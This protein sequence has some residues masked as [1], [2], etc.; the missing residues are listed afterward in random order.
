MLSQALLSFALLACGALA[1]PT[2]SIT[3][4]LEKRLAPHKDNKCEAEINVNSTS[5]LP[6]P[7]TLN[8]EKKPN[9]KPQPTVPKV[10]GLGG[11]DYNWSVA[12]RDNSNNHIGS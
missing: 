3:N 1:A 5:T 9:P 6:S 12:V 11:L 8:Q 10:H 4:D 2:P 7:Q